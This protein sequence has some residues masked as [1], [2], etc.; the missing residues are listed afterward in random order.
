M[1]SAIMASQQANADDEKSFS[2]VMTWFVGLYEGASGRKF[3]G[4][5]TE[6][7]IAEAQDHMPELNGICVPLM[8]DFGERLQ[9][10]G[11]RVEAAEAG[12]AKPGS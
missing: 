3:D 12:K 10:W 5:A 6:R 2:F 7:D 11:G 9:T 8:Q 4:S 1:W